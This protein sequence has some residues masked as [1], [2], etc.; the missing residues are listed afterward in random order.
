MTAFSSKPVHLKG[1][2]LSWLTMRGFLFH[3]DIVL[4]R[5]KKSNFAFSENIWNSSLKGPQNSDRLLSWN[6][7]FNSQWY[8][9]SMR[10]SYFTEFKTN[11]FSSQL[12]QCLV[13]SWSV[14]NLCWNDSLKRLRW[15]WVFHVLFKL[16][17]ISSP[18][19]RTI[20]RVPKF[21]TIATTI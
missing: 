1:F 8:F 2:S 17:D 12:V 6:A 9:K 21:F 16:E 10:S 15:P 11:Y 14:G 3:R 13:I 20:Y 19:A 18:S 7:L 5:A 4:R